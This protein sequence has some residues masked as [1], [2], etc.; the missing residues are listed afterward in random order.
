MNAH[1]QMTLGTSV[2]GGRRH[3]QPCWFAGKSQAL[4]L[5]ARLTLCLVIALIYE[6]NSAIAEQATGQSIKQEIP[7]LGTTYDRNWEQVGVVA[8]VYL[9]WERRADAEGMRVRFETKPGRFS[10]QAQDAVLHAISRV[11]D[12][13]H[14]DTRSWT[15]TLSLPYPGVTMYGDSLSAMVGLSVL[16]LAKGDPLP[17]DRVITGTITTDGN[18]GPVGGVPLKI[19]AAHQEHLRRVVIPE[20]FDV[21]DGDW[22]TPFLMVVSP[23]K[24]LKH[25][26][27][28]L[29]DRP[30][31]IPPQQLTYFSIR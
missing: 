15:V 10:P 17:H 1:P 8:K 19:V 2:S 14:V 18:I 22:Q 4:W 6:T 24:S 29:T 7:I 16:A 25:A 5:F 28:A 23:V 31:S 30:F 9:T 11:A 3:P 27:K 26:Y 21:A 20:E 13:S 12:A